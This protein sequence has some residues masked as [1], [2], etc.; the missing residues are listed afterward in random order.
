MIS[1]KNKMDKVP[2]SEEQLTEEAENLGMTLVYSEDETPYFMSLD[3]TLHSL[4]IEEK[5]CTIQSLIASE[6][7]GNLATKW[8]LS[9]FSFF[10]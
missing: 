9:F 6:K 3:E 5:N 10:S 8:V 2:F 4:T 1:D 7:D